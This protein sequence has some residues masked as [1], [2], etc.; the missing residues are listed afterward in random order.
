MDGGPEVPPAIETLKMYGGFNPFLD[1]WWARRMRP[2]IEA[3]YGV[4]CFN[5]FLDGWW[6][7]SGHVVDDLLYS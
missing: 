2:P 4:F 3:R 5:P 1:G 7:R 6:A